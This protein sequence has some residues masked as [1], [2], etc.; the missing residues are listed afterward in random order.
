MIKI[1][2]GGLLLVQEGCKIIATALLGSSAVGLFFATAP[3]DL[4]IV[5]FCSSILFG[6][7]SIKISAINKD[8]F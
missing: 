1:D 3:I 8:K 7:C 6:A 4:I 2:R 5:G